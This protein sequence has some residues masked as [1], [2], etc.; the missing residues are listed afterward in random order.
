MSTHSYFVSVASVRNLKQ[1]AAKKVEG[2]SSSHLS[3][4]VAAALDFKTHAALIAA[5]RGNVTVEASKPS[6]ERMNSRLRQFGY[7]VRPDLKLLP[8]LKHSYGF[9]KRYPIKAK[10]GARWNAWRNL[11]VAAINAGLEQRIFGLLPG[12]DWWPGADE[13][14]Y[15]GSRGHYRF[16]FDGD[17]AAVVTVASIGAGELSIDVL[18]DPNSADTELHG[19]FGIQDG[20]AS[21]HGWFERRL[22]V[23]LMDGGEDFSCK[24][25]I[26][27]RLAAKRVEPTG[28]SDIGSFIM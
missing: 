19:R 10:R 21:A 17:I 23:W 27:P 26:Q 14:G 2:V 11:M 12:E 25:M 1:L 3:E 20:K 22:G 16:V 4:A 15:G 28:Y 6:N 9:G 8:E 18:L 7:Q 24:R 13:S 5:L